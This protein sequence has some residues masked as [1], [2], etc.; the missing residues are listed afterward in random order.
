M[1]AR[2]R[3]AVK[4]TK[5]VCHFIFAQ[6][7]N[8]SSLQTLKCVEIFN[9]F[10]CLLLFKA[11]IWV[12]FSRRRCE[13]PANSAHNLNLKHNRPL[14]EKTAQ[15][16]RLERLGLSIRFEFQMPDENEFQAVSMLMFSYNDAA[17]GVWNRW[18]TSLTSSR[19]DSWKWHT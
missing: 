11:F 2:R 3:Y 4:L 5:P 8:I 13:R 12:G 6:V 16:S 19:L 14:G 10:S 7:S 1:L 9:L 18:G 17:F 15:A